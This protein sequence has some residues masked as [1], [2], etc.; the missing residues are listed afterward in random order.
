MSWGDCRV[1][2]AGSDVGESPGVVMVQFWRDVGLVRGPVCIASSQNVCSAL[3]LVCWDAA[4][5]KWRL[6]PSSP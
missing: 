4:K 5:K 6:Q 3:L 2:E 1:A